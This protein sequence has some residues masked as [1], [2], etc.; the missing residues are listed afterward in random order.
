[1]S[2]DAVLLL[3]LLKAAIALEVLVPIGL[4]VSAVVALGRPY[5]DSEMTAFFACGI[6]PMRIFRV[7]PAL[8][9]LSPVAVLYGV[10]VWLYRR[11]R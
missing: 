8:I 6:S 4:H 3:V 5:T 10:A 1:M 11:V 7:H 9:T 2:A